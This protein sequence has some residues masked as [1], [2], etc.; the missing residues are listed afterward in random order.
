MVISRGLGNSIISIRL[1]NRP[2]L[3]FVIKNSALKHK[4]NIENSLKSVTKEKTESFTA[5][6]RLEKIFYY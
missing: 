3:I 5:R 1:F 4:F 2:E 6:V